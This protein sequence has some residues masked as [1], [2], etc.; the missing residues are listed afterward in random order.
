[1][2]VSS[3]FHAGKKLRVLSF[4]RSA[5]FYGFLVSVCFDVIKWTIVHMC[6]T[7]LKLHFDF[8]FSETEVVG[9]GPPRSFTP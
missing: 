3:Q 8:I 1:M 2:N 7:S 9:A 4:M 5:I 6:L